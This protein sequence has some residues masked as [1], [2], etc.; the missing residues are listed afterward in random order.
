MVELMINRQT[1][2]PFLQGLLIIAVLAG[3]SWATIAGSGVTVTGS[4]TVT[5][6]N[7]PYDVAVLP[8]HDYI[9]VTNYGNNTVS[10]ANAIT[11]TILGTITGFNLPTGIAS[12]P[13]GTFAYVADLGANELMRIDVATNTITEITSGFNQPDFVSVS[14]DGKTAYVTNK[15]NNTVSVVDLTPISPVNVILT[16]FTVSPSPVSAGLPL[17]FTV[18]LLNNGMF[19]SG[20]IG[21]NLVITGPQSFAFSYSVAALPPSHSEQVS[22]VLGSVTGAAGSYTASATASFVYSSVTSQSNAKSVTYSVTPPVTPPVPS[23]TPSSNVTVPIS[24]VVTL[25]Q[26]QFTQVPFY[27]A[28][29]QGSSLLSSIGIKDV[30]GLPE[31]ISMTIPPQFTKIFTLSSSS[32]YLLPNESLLVQMVFNSN[33]V[34]QSGTYVIPINIGLKALNGTL[35]NRTQYMTYV[36]SKS[37]NNASLYNQISLSQNNATVTTTLVGARN[38]SFTNATLVT[39]LPGSVISSTSQIKTY[40]L[41]ATVTLTNATTTMS[42]MPQRKGQPPRFLPSESASPSY[43]IIKWLVPYLPAGKSVTMSYTITNPLN[44]GLL[45]AIQ[46]LLT[47]TSPVAPTSILHVVSIQTPTLYANSTGR[48]LVGVLYTGTSQQQVKFMLTTTGTV[49]INNPI[50]VVNATPNQLLQQAFIVKTYNATGTSLCDLSIETQNASVSYTLPVLVLE[51]PS[52][53]TPAPIPSYVI[54][55]ISL[56]Y[57]LLAL[58]IVVIIMLAIAI[59]KRRKR[60]RYNPE[61]AKELIRVREQIKRSD[62]HAQAL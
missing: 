15:G 1:I 29:A 9:Y 14:S 57:A 28:L 11:N 53:I 61:R 26:L 55:N 22:F 19:A 44:V 37:T 41:P 60:Q 12:T 10:I 18:N 52:T 16:G 33:N 54:P 34:T 36:V 43:A 32:L 48:I 59:R 62:E 30:I 42:G 31:T 39:I 5:G 23:P 8:N 51:K 4:S 3:T 47:V 38:V 17:T 27:S 13:N 35:V 40:G 45:T 2:S 20:T 50:Q 25:P 7:S 49:E 6:F 56:K 58:G 24:P 46:N 21:V